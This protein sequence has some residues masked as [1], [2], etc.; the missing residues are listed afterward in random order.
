[1][2]LYWKTCRLCFGRFIGTLAQEGLCEDCKETHAPPVRCPA[3][4]G[5]GKTQPFD[6]ACPECRSRAV[7]IHFGRAPGILQAA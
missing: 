3:C 2:S 4:K 1:M 5:D 7:L 6:V